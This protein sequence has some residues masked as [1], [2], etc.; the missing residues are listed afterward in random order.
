MS[1]APNLTQ[2]QTV[3]GGAATMTHLHPSKWQSVL[4]VVLFYAAFAALW[5]LFSDDAILLLTID[6]KKLI[7]I[8]KIKGWVYVAVT[9]LLLYFLLYQHWKAY[10]S[11]LDLRLNTLKLIESVTNSSDDAIFAK[12]LNGRYLIFNEAASRCVNKPVAQVIGQDD[13]AIF[14]P[15]QAAQLF[16]TNQRILASGETEHLEEHLL[17]PHGMRVFYVIKGALH[18]NQGKIIGTFGIS[19]DI[20]ERAQAADELRRYRDH[21]E[22]LV[23]ERTRDLE[24][25]K[26][27]AE[28]ANLAKS[29]FLANMSHEIRTPL[30]AITGMAHL[31]RRG[32]L[33]A[34]Q[35]DYLDKLTGA[36]YHLLEVINAI[37]DLSKIE[38]GRFV[39]ADQPLLINKVLENVALILSERI[40]AK[41]L[42]LRTEVAS[43][44][45]VLRG[46]P[47]RLQQALLNY[48]NNALKF[49]EHGSVTMRV[50]VIDEQSDNL[51]L[52]FEVLDT[53]IGI[54]A[55]AQ[56]R[57]FRAFEQAD[58]TT[59]RQYGGTGLGLAIT[60]KLAALMDGEAGLSSQAG[61]GSCFWFTARL[62]KDEPR[63]CA[64]TQ[65]TEDA[66]LILNQQ[67]AGARILVAEDEALNREIAGT[68]LNDVG[69][70][71]E[72]AENG[73]IALTKVRTDRYALILMDMQMPKLD[74]LDATRCI[75]A[76]PEG[77]S[78]PIVA[79]TANAFAEDR[80]RCLAA[81]MNDFIG[82][83]FLPEH[84]Y[85]VLLHWLRNGEAG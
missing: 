33:S 64:C 67:F 9:S 21:L 66:A 13:F 78:V 79:M 7:Y 34:E 53:G 71:A 40:A 26:L 54:P 24:R 2:W 49:T 47:T 76:L 39:L 18:D 22:T 80:E 48:A 82:K 30:N 69:L 85:S 73:A 44:L 50:H 14:P 59:T 1:G 75:R 81:G 35:Q 32:T 23:A 58:C 37:L 5:I 29:A 8:S 68:L 84:L 16:A 56:T 60:R 77:R 25:A 45:P 4:R 41:D 20:T 11:S 28:S 17:T 46:D 3:F 74:G 42:V 31:M 61:I 12:D 62:R 65:T 72:F 43:N 83:P 52:R 27:A 38:A 15:E 57:L 36:G 10:C 19:R 55:E 6:P 63:N 51:L 70:C